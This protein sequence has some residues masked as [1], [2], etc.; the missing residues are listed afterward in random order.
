MVVAAHDW[1]GCDYDGARGKGH[2]GTAPKVLGDHQLSRHEE[3]L[4][5][6]YKN[7]VISHRIDG[8]YGGLMVNDG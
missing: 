4:P 5:G 8:T 7:L 1:R 6:S 2:G 3:K